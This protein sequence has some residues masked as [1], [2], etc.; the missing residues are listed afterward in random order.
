MTVNEKVR[1]G[2]PRC[3]QVAAE[4]QE[5]ANMLRPWRLHARQIRDDV[6][7]T[8]LYPTM[9]A[10]EASSS[11]AGEPGS[12]IDNTWLTPALQ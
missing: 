6:V 3:R 7:K 8:Q 2:R 9:L 4:R 10:D 11:G 5:P 1:I 12:R